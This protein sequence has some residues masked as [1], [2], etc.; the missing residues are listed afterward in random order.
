M[1]SSSDTH[2]TGWLLDVSIDKY[3]AI[4]WV[5]TLEGKILKVFDIYQPTFY[6]LPKDRHT[7]AALFQVLSRQST[8][9]KLEWQDKFTDLFE[10]DTRRMKRLICVYPE[11]ILHYK[12]LIKRLKHDPRVAQLFN[13]DLSHIQ[14]YLFTK[15]KIQP[16]SKVEVEYDK[17]DSRLI[18][19]RRINEDEDVA[20]P[21]FS[22]LYFEIHTASSSYNLGHDQGPIREI[23]VR[24]R[25]ELEISFEGHEENI[26]TDFKTYCKKVRKLMLYPPGRVRQ[27]YLK[28]LFP[29]R[30]F[31][32]EISKGYAVC[33]PERVLF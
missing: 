3:L 32:L 33:L 16:T 9:K 8:V 30:E 23:R 24:Y 21:P 12:P 10:Y 5:K 4:I 25:E 15:L 6:V 27:K 22:I 11:S 31:E 18:N 14:Q 26:L 13:T 29:I 2:S 20:M 28:E 7:G 1:E 17:N 19:I